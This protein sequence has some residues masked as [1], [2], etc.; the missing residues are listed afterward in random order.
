MFVLIG[1]GIATSISWRTTPL[2][3]I[4][5]FVME[6]VMAFV[7][8]FY[9]VGIVMLTYYFMTKPLRYLDD[10]INATG[11]MLE[12][13]DE[14]IVLPMAMRNVEDELNMLRE[15]SI[16]F[17]GINENLDFFVTRIFARVGIG[18]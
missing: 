2:Y 3:Y 7:I 10:I 14:V 5:Q 17:A 13:K 4:G 15:Q 6:Y 16:K 12:N 9:S 1:I 8:G 11:Q 18:A